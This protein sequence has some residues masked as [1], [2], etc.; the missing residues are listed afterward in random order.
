MSAQDT[1]VGKRKGKAKWEERASDEQNK[2]RLRN[3][4]RM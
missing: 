3:D 2:E 4:A 1:T